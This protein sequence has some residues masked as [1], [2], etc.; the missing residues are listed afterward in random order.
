MDQWISGYVPAVA[1]RNHAGRRAAGRRAV[2]RPAVRDQVH[3]AL[4]LLSAPTAPKLIAEVH[5][6]FFGA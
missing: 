4:T 2:A 3:H 5:N 1:R 6:A